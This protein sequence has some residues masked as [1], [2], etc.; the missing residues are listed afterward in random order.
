M[1]NAAWSKL[2]SPLLDGGKGEHSANIKL[3]W[4]RRRRP[5]INVSKVECAGITRVQVQAIQ[6]PVW[7][8]RGAK[9]MEKS[10]NNCL[11]D[12]VLTASE[13]LQAPVKVF[14]GAVSK[15]SKHM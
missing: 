13:E 3:Q 10:C 2:S 9:E 8:V 14:N 1:N 6:E 11:P 15:A 12:E 5:R 7:T 4:E